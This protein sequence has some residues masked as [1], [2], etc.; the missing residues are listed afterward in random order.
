M[1]DFLIFMVAPIV[2]AIWISKDKRI[3]RQNRKMA[4]NILLPVTALI[5]VIILAGTS[6]K[7]KTLDPDKHLPEECVVLPPVETNVRSWNGAGH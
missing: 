4:L 6:D 2:L 3:S 5:F 7:C 1:G